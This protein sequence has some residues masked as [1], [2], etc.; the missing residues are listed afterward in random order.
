MRKVTLIFSLFIISIIKVTATEQIPDLLIIEND[1]FYLK[2]FPLEQLRLKERIKINPFEYGDY[3][4]P[5]TGCYRGYVATWKVIDD[6]LMLIEV[7]KVDSISE[8]LDIVEYFKKADFKPAMING[9][10][11]ADW[12]SD[13]LKRYNY[14]RYYFNPERFYLGV[15]YLNESNKKV[16][17]IFNKGLLRANKINNI[18]SYKTGDILT[19]EISYYRK[20][21]LKRGLTGVDAVIKENNGEMVRVE[22]MNF[23]TTKKMALKEIKRIMKIREGQEYWI[24]PRYWDRKNE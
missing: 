12:Y 15:D 10:V 1:T 24:N 5:H 4:F 14:F 13:T 9:I 8:K 21:F 22:I 2:T 6:K 3:E 20:W 18:N 16:E 7:E 17:L 19:K 11:H 23:G